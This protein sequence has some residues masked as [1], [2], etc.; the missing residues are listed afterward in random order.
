[1]TPEELFIAMHILH[2]EVCEG[3]QLEY[4]CNLGS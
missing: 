4:K 1:M 3:M 2:L